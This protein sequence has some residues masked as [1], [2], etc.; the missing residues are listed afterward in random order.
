MAVVF[1]AHL[2]ALVFG[3]VGLL[4]MLPHPDLWAHD[5]HAVRVF[6][7]SMKYAGS[8]HI[9]LGAAAVLL[10]GVFVLGWRKTL[11]FAVVACGLSLSSELIG[12]GTGWPFGNYAY[13]DFLGTK[14][15]GRVPYTIPFSWFYMGLSSYVVGAV[16][17]QKLGWRHVGVWTCVTGAALLTIWDLVLDPAMAHD[18]LRIRFWVWSDHGAY[19]GMPVKNLIGWSVTGLLFMAVSRLLWRDDIRLTRLP[20]IP[21]GIYLANLAFAMVISASVGLWLPIVFAIALGAIPVAALWLDRV[22][23]VLVTRRR[24]V[25]A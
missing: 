17:V 25:N 24:P 8:I 12:T 7:F 4:I 15:L 14:V 22:P 5:R 11:I 19:F 13:T 10:F 6:D 21:A 3:L 20:W 9:L 2:A 16:I 18:S 1:T 23:A